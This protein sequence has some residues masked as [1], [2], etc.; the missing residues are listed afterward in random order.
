MKLLLDTHAFLWWILDDV[1]LSLT[2]RKAIAR[3][4]EEVFVSAASAWEIAVKTALG[5][6]KLPQPPGRLVPRHIKASGFQPL[7]IRVEHALRVH[8]LPDHH[9]DPFDRLL[10]AQAVEDRLA[11]VTADGQ[12]RRYPVR[13]IW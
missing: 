4:E 2:A 9:H 5:R 10:I 6:L 11:I 12:F 8:D 7:P 3:R 13:V 1:R